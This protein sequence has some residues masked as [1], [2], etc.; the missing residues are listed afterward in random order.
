MLDERVLQRLADGAWHSGESLGMQLGKSRAAV[1]KSIAGLRRLGLAV[2]SAPGRGY[3]WTQ[4]AELLDRAA[5]LA[6]LSGPVRASLQQLD[7]HLHCDSTSARLLDGPEPR[8]GCLCVSLAEFQSGGRGRRGRSWLSP[9]ASGLCLSLGRVFSHAPARLAGL[10]LA[11]GVL[12]VEALEQL[13][14]QGVGLK[15]PN[16]LVTADGKLGGI[17][18]DVAGEPAGPLR[19]IVGI[20]LN[21]H[22]PPALPEQLAV[23]PA[24]LA[25]AGLAGLLADAAARRNRIAA[26]LISHLGAGLQ[27]FE[28]QGFAAFAERW[29]AHDRLYGLPVAVDGPGGRQRGTAQGIA[30]DGALLLA[31]GGEIVSLYSGEVS[32]R[33]C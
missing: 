26:Q 24:A 1:W 17:L 25:P 28:Q 15:W 21:I 10:G 20:G 27:E 9:P 13:G 3:R 23:D 11:A 19:A 5:I 2:E 18:V 32:L 8:P 33:A 29:Q 4:P 14:A 6:E 12:V 30:A 31:T 22:L 16:D 7:V